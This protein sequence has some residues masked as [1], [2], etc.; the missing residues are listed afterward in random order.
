MLWLYEMFTNPEVLLICHAVPCC[1]VLQDGDEAKAKKDKKKRKKEEAEDEANGAAEEADGE[2]KK[3]KK[4]KADK[5]AAAAEEDGAE[6]V[7]GVAQHLEGLLGVFR[8]ALLYCMVAVSL[9]L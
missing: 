6:K 1:A 4:K 2:K 8:P 5:E 3:K 7:R 9:D